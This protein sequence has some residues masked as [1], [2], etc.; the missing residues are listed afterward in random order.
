MDGYVGDI[1]KRGI[2]HFRNRM[3]QRI[4]EQEVCDAVGLCSETLDSVPAVYRSSRPQDV[5][6]EF[7]EKVGHADVELPISLCF[8]GLYTTVLAK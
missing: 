7:C 6:C 4:N 3:L 2:F 5:Q 8:S 1:D